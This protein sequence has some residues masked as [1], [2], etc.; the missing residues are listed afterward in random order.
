MLQLFHRFMLD[1]CSRQSFVRSIRNVFLHVQIL[2]GL[3]FYMNSC[4]YRNGCLANVDRHKDLKVYFMPTHNLV[5][6][7]RRLSTHE[8]KAT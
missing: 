8:R 6:L 7:I 3:S 1:L 2:L 5:I 4:K